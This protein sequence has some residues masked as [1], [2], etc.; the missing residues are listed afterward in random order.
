MDFNQE[1]DQYF[2]LALKTLDH[3]WGPYHPLHT[4]IYGI[5]A[6]LLLSKNK[7]EDAKYLY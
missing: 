6:Y 4:T 5:L 1:A 3:H 2:S 7:M